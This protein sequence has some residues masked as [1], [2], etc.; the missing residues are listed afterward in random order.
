MNP[1]FKEATASF[2][3]SVASPDGDVIHIREADATD[4]QALHDV[5]AAG[6]P[7]DQA[8]PRERIERRLRSPQGRSLIA[9]SEH[10]GIAVGYLSGVEYRTADYVAGT[11]W[12]TFAALAESTKPLPS[13]KGLSL[14]LI[15]VSTRPNAPRGTGTELLR[16]MHAVAAEEGFHRMHYGIKLPHLAEAA[17]KGISPERYVEGLVAGEFHEDVYRMARNCGARPQMLVADYYLDGDSLNYGLMME[18][19]L[20]PMESAP[21]RNA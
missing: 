15:T 9:F 5:E 2:L 18:H 21:G 6:W 4:L 10:L 11:P 19:F 8:A 14:Y 12:T 16:A 17:K 3:S 1:P 20:N 7:S 13:R